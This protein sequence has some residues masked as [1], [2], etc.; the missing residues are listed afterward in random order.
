[1]LNLTKLR[2]R[3]VNLNDEWSSLSAT[4]MLLVIDIALA[5]K[6]HSDAFKNAHGVL[7]VGPEEK[8][9]EVNEAAER[10][11]KLLEDVEVGDET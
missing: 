5:A 7:I 1:M 4:E 2:K 8:Q 11:D 9:I 10:L 3:H 6:R